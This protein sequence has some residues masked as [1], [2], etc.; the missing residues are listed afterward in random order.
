MTEA[1]LCAMLIIALAAGVSRWI[2]MGEGAVIYPNVA[3][4]AL[5]I[6][7]RFQVRCASRT[8][9]KHRIHQERLTKRERAI[10]MATQMGRTDL[11]KRLE[12]L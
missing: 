11:V 12:A 4:E 8:L 1:N 3:K 2:R 10:Q 5:A 9:T 7:H 6:L